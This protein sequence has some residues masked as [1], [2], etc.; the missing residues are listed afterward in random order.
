MKAYSRK[1]VIEVPVGTKLMEFPQG[2]AISGN[3][4]NNEKPE[5]VVHNLADTEAGPQGSWQ[6]A[7]SRYGAVVIHDITDQHGVVL[8]ERF[9]RT[10]Q[11][12][13]ALQSVLEAARMMGYKH[14]TTADRL[15][16]ETFMTPVHQLGKI[17]GVYLDMGPAETYVARNAD[18][19]IHCLTDD[20][21]STLSP[22]E[23]TGK[24]LTESGAQIDLEE[25]PVDQSAATA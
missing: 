7:D 11:N 16:A 14:I 6:G 18:G 17:A 2:A 22:Q 10:E 8:L 23:L 19:V 24:Y 12:I 5:I 20:E 3:G 9:R 1:L 21:V 15:E 13:E 4:Q 25:I